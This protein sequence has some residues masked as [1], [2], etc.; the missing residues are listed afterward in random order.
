MKE[1]WEKLTARV[2]A[3]ALRERVMIFAALA[4]L[5]VYLSY[6]ALAVPMVAKQQQARAQIVTQQDKMSSLNAQIAERIASAAQDPD[7]AARMRLERLLSEQTALGSNLRTVQRGLVAPEKMAPLLEQI[8]HGHGRLKLMSLRSLPVTTVD[9]AAP[10]TATPGAK[11]DGA[12]GAA[13]GMTP[14]DIAKAVVATAAQQA[15]ANAGQT[16][17]LAAPSAPAAPAPKAKAM[18]YRHGVEMML[19][20]GY[21]DMVSYM[22]ALERLPVQL[23]WG[24]ATLDASAYPDVKL[25]LTLYTLSLDEKWMKL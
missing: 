10:L 3:L 11:A 8:L 16:A 17:A 21:V 22:E 6:S 1:Q 12:A 24:K 4:S 23:F 15:N 14:A 5:L 19:Q 20:G 2:D 9:E 13:Q 18:L 7:A 25:S